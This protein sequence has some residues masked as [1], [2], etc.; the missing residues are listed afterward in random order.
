M[1]QDNPKCPFCHRKLQWVIDTLLCPICDREIIYI[2]N[3]WIKKD[4]EN[5]KVGK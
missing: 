2:R 3:G 1:I 5:M 4:I